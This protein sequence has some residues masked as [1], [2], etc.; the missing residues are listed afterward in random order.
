MLE[1][2]GQSLQELFDRQR[3]VRASSDPFLGIV[4]QFIELQTEDEK[5]QSPELLK[6]RMM[7]GAQPGDMFVGH[8]DDNFNEWDERLEVCRAVL[9]GIRIEK[10]GAK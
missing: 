9:V 2:K 4:E 1:A 7:M 10:E 5:Q 8:S 6:V 3:I